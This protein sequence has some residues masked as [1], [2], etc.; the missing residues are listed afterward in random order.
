MKLGKRACS[1]ITVAAMTLAAP[2]QASAAYMINFTST[3]AY[4]NGPA[5]SFSAV[6]GPKSS[7]MIFTASMLSN[8]S[9]TDGFT[10]QYV[11]LNGSNVGDYI[12]LYARNPAVPTYGGTT[13][14]FPVGSLGTPGSYTSIV[15]NA[16]Y[17][18][19][20]SITVTKV[21]GRAPFFD[22]PEPSTWALMILGFGGIGAAMRRRASAGR[23]AVRVSYSQ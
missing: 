10:C 22:V 13:Y 5:G 20:A 4:Q 1:A 8:C 18:Y 6:Y 14:K 9:M 16:P 11:H 15:D 7:S 21:P 17:T 12:T 3:T 2:K 19:D 23:G